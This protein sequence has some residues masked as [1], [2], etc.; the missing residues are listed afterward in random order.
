MNYGGEG[1]VGERRLSP[2]ATLRKGFSWP[3]AAEP[4]LTSA[5]AGRRSAHR[6]SALLQL[7]RLG[8]IREPSTSTRWRAESSL[9]RLRSSRPDAFVARSPSHAAQDPKERLTSAP[10]PPQL[11][12]TCTARVASAHRDGSFCL[13][14]GLWGKHY[15]IH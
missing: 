7:F 8:A 15:A 14:Y 5:R 11:R 3:M 1:T 13:V 4:R 2:D 6:E 12:N 10:V 9:L